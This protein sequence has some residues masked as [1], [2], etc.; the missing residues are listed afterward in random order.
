M[1]N[2]KSRREPPGPQASSL[3]FPMKTIAPFPLT[4]R[5]DDQHIRPIRRVVFR[6]GQSTR[7]C[8]S[9]RSNRHRYLR[10]NRAFLLEFGREGFADRLIFLRQRSSQISDGPSPYK[11]C[12]SVVDPPRRATE[13][14]HPIFLRSVEQLADNRRHFKLTRKQIGLIHPKPKPLRCFVLLQMPN[15]RS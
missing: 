14:T 8:R 7:P 12:T 11:I 2:L 13:R 1:R 4:G 9:H 3:A 10:Y 15:S 6:I 5:G